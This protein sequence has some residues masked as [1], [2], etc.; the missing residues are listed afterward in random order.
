M[1]DALHLRPGDRLEVECSGDKLVLERERPAKGLHSV[2]GWLVYDNGG[3]PISSEDVR[4][5]IEKDREDRMH[6]ILGPGFKS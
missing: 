4:N 5:W 2:N 1:R 3:T 6:H